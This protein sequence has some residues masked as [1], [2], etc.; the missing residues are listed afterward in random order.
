VYECDNSSFYVREVLG[1]NETMFS[2]LK[3]F[4]IPHQ[5]NN[6][7][8]DSLEK[9]ALTGMFFL[10]VLSFAATNVFSLLW[11]HSSWLVGTV[12]PAVVVTRTNEERQ[13][14]SLGSL[15][16]SSLLDDAAKRKAEHMAKNGYFAHYSPEGVSPWHWFKVVDYSFVHAG[17]NLAVHF[18]D[19]D[20]LVDAWMESPTHRAN[21]MN[22]QYTQIGVGTAKGTYEGYDTVFVVQMFGT[23]AAE[24]RQPKAAVAGETKSL[25]SE[26]APAPI[27]EVAMASQLPS[28]VLAEEMSSEVAKEKVTLEK[29]QGTPVVVEAVEEKVTESVPAENPVVS[30][31]K[32]MVSEDSFIAT[33]APGI[34]AE[35][36]GDVARTQDISSG[37]RV[38]TSPH[39]LLRTLYGV[40]GSVVFVSLIL[41]VFIEV[42]R[43]RPVQVAYGVG[44][45][46][47][48]F[49]LFYIQW[50]LIDGA[51]VL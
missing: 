43:Q 4:F 50:V 24:L 25:L 6:Y 7:A 46:A 29:E 31:T 42:R 51:V 38:L 14:K 8:P 41:A 3:N 10:I 34:P 1:Y 22:G 13:D 37:T 32:T 45:M 36:T 47:C 9:T 49:L 28:R 35:I 20:A 21:I 19:T 27:D 40:I 26:L 44:L 17:E 30:E 16:R 12:L 18:N 15:T 48:M 33:T 39:L 23:P 11:V 2:R 5:G